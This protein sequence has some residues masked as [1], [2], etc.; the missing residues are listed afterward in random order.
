MPLLTPPEGPYD[1]GATTFVL[2]LDKPIPTGTAKIHN[3][4]GELEPALLA[5]EVTFT[6]FY[7][8]AVSSRQTHK[9]GLPWLAR[10]VL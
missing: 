5:E 9:K 8:T 10:C 3:A 2:P 4:R 6:A 1:V 7:P